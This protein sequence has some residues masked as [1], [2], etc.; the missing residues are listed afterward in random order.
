MGITKTSIC[1]GQSPRAMERGIAL[2]ISTARQDQEVLMLKSLI[3]LLAAAGLILAASQ[4]AS[5]FLPG[6]SPV[7][8]AAQELGTAIEV[9]KKIKKFK[10]RPPGWDQGVKTGWGTGNVPPGQ[11]GRW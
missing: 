7:I 5:A 1:S 8:A 2:R 3:V 9:K 10:K 6:Q 11:R 4:S